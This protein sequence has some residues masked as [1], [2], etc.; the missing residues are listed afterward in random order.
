MQLGE[1]SVASL[2]QL[3][4]M[5]VTWWVSG[6]VGEAQCALVHPVTHS[7]LSLTHSFSTQVT[8]GACV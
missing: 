2:Q 4:D 3:C 7:C 5:C 6:W 1:S 8:P